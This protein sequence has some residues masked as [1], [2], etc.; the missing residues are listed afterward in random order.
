MDI[1][2]WFSFINHPAIGVPPFMKTPRN[3][4]FS[5]RSRLQPNHPGTKIA[6]VGCQN[7]KVQKKIENHQMIQKSKIQPILGEKPTKMEPLH[8][9]GAFTGSICQILVLVQTWTVA[10]C[11]LQSFELLRAQSHTPS[12]GKNGAQ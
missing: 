1:F 11:S 8:D 2:Q 4:A 7:H 6:E 12:L 9:E 10:K 3:Q 5:L